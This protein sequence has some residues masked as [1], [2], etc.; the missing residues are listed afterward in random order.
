MENRW[1]HY[2]PPSSG[3]TEPNYSIA[4]DIYLTGKQEGKQ[5]PDVTINVCLFNLNVASMRAYLDRW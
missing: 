2:D 5:S 4:G 1:R 3:S